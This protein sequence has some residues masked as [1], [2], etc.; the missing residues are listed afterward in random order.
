MSVTTAEHTDWFRTLAR[1]AKF[2]E[3]DRLG[4]A[5]YIDQSVRARAR[6]SWSSGRSTSIARPI[7]VGVDG[8]Q[9]VP[10]LHEQRLPLRIQTDDLASKP[11]G[12]LATHL[13]ALNHISYDGSWYSG[14]PVGDVEGPSVAD[15]A[16]EGLVTRGCYLN[17]AAAQDREW[18]DPDRPVGAAD[19]E[20]ALAR[21][22]VRFESGDALLLDMGR[23]Q[24]EAAG[25]R[26]GS[27]WS[28]P[29]EYRQ[30]GLGADAAHWIAEH[31]VSVLCWDFQDA[32]HP[33]QPKFAVHGLIW[34]IGQLIVDNCHFG[35]LRPRVDSGQVCV[36]IA[37]QAPSGAS[38]VTVNPLV[39]H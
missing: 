4:T 31:E 14:W 11:H 6:E 25:E 28:S 7:Q 3:R 15:I 9:H 2:G 18:V 19:I 10:T 36:V 13:D 38:G 21:S 35:L 24:Y 27:Q 8:T 39:L 37:P 30:P 26:V 32:V 23:D 22:S 34:A 5:N 16:P 1:T 12:L 29:P 17:L 20:R 33:D